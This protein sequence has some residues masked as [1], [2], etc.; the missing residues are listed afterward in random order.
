MTTTSIRLVT[1]ARTW[2]L[3]AALTA[4]LV[5]LGALIGGAFL[6]PCRMRMPPLARVLMARLSV[7]GAA[8]RRCRRRRS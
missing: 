4:L 3:I 7:I 5:S 6:Y 8:R 1:H 2:L